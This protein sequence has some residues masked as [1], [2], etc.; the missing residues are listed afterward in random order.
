MG[1][2][3]GDAIMIDYQKLYTRM[4]NAATDALEALENRN[5]GTAGDILRTAQQDT[6]RLYIEAE[7]ESAPLV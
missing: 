2:S 3:E 7:E 4:F 1:L 6:E 5:I